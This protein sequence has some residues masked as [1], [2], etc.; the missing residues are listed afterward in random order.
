MTAQVLLSGPGGK[1]IQARAFIDPGAA[2]SL[3]SSKIAQQL[4]LPLT[5]THLQF[6]AVLATPC[7][8]VKHL[9][10]VSISPLQGGKT[11]PV[12]AAVVTTVTSDIPS[13][14]IDPVDNLPHLMGLGLAD[15]TFYL[16]GKIDILLGS[17]QLMIQRPLITGTATE[18][19]AQETIFGWAIIGPVRSRGK[20]IQPISANCAQVLSADENLNDL[21]AAF[22]KTEELDAPIQSLSQQE[23][24]VETLYADIVP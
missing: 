16:P 4:S 13:Q 5:K 7:K 8:S 21:L 22:W 24:Q 23:E 10:N 17:D 11:I 6:S 2:M 3:I 20:E 18:P 12:R 19:A 9:T 1:K 14:E 15:P